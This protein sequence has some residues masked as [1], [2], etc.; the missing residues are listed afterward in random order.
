VVG[1]RDQ[2]ARAERNLADNAARHA[3]STVTFT[4]AEADGEAV[5]TAADDGPGIAAEDRER[6]FER[7]TRLDDARSAA[8]GGTGLGLAITREIV[9]RH[10]GRVTID[11]DWPVGTRLVVVLPAHDRAGPGVTN[12]SPP[13]S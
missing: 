5:L 12:G 6:V 9:E 11:P 8:S 13:S 3:S 4:V 7:F 2:L 1:D 10:G